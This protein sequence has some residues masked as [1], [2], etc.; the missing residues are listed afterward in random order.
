MD[1]CGQVSHWLHCDA[2][3]VLQLAR[4]DASLHEHASEHLFGHY[5]SILRI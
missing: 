1:D 5:N 2:T 3:K 4:L